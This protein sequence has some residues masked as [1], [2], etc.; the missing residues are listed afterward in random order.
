MGG[1]WE[2]ARHVDKDEERQWLVK[3]QLVQETRETMD[4]GST[5]STRE[6]AH[7]NNRS[8]VGDRHARCPLEL[9]L[10]TNLLDLSCSF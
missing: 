8:R 9:S 4:T 6:R 3:E 5:D 1:C 2:E 10:Q 7:V